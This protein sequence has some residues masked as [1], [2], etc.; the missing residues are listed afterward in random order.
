MGFL[1]SFSARCG[2]AAAAAASF[3]LPL[4]ASALPVGAVLNTTGV[5]TFAVTLRIECSGFACGL[6][7]FGSPYQQTQTSTLTGTT[8]I[9]ADDTAD[10]LQ[11]SSDSAGTLNLL[12]LTGTNVVFTGLP[13]AVGGPNVTVS[14]LVAGAINAGLA[15]ILGFDLNSPPQAIAFAT[16]GVGAL[17]IGATATTSSA[18]FA[19][20]VLAPVPVNALGTFLYTG[21]GDNDDFPEFAIQNL[22]GTFQSLT[23]TTTILGTTIRVTLRATFTLNFAGESFTLIPE[24]ASFAMVGLGLMG[25]A[26]AA[27]R[28]RA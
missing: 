25:F 22:R 9:Y 11:F 13:A 23:S 1:R 17:Q 5:N 4:S 12:S 10:S 19:N 27:K 28:R 18:Q 14:N 24:P 21:D 7:G 6:A 3:V 15:G 2:I 26:F 20:L 16:S 8:G